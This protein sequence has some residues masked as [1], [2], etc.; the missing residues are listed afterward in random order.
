MVGGR[1]FA[2]D[3]GQVNLALGK[4]HQAPEEVENAV[5][6]AA[7]CWN[8]E[9]ISVEGGGSG[10]Q[11]GSSWKPFVLATALE[12]GM[13]DT[14]GYSAPST[15]RIPNC[16]GDDNCTINN[17]EGSAGGSATLRSATA[18][19][20]NTVYAQVIQDTGVA[21]V[22]AM[23]KKLGISSAWVAT[24]ERHNLE[25]ALGAQEVSP[26]DMASAYGVFAANGLRNPATPVLWVKD[27]GGAFLE[28]NR[29]RVPERVLEASVA[30]NVTDILKG[31][32]TGGTGTAADIGRPAAGK[33]G[34]SSKNFD[35]WFV[36]FTPQLSTAVW[37]G[38][39]DQ[40]TIEIDG[41]EVTG[42][43]FSSKI[44]KAY[45]DVA[46][47]GQPLVEFPPRADVGS[48]KNLDSNSDSGESTFSPRPRRSRSSGTGSRST[49]TAE[50]EEETEPTES[51]EPSAEPEQTGEPEQPPTSP[52]PPPPSSPQPP[53]PE[54][55]EAPPPPSPVATTAPR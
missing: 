36:G 11:P 37:L 17:Y 12:Q 3:S 39:A 35:A 20:Y 5:D 15:Y 28:D 14:K 45:T 54:E 10:R 52:Q 38:Y 9:A 32:I 42:G 22:G 2:A 44:W 26:L 31:V 43:G 8:P 48:R 51:A 27:A 7:T 41:V 4:C 33:T 29:E 6:V 25:Y 16:V 24:P 46:L 19:S 50:P 21:E 49:A 55:T 1:D 47:E 40:K 23:A 13:P 53:P 34:T 30:Y 18:R